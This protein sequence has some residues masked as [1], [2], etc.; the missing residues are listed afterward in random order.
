MQLR[1]LLAWTLVK[2][3][4]EEEAA[5]HFKAMA[6]LDLDAETQ[7]SVLLGL[8]C[9]A[10][11]QYRHRQP[12]KRVREAS[13]S[14]QPARTLEVVEEDDAEHGD[15]DLDIPVIEVTPPP[16]R[17][18]PPSAPEIPEIPVIEELPDG[19]DRAG[20][21]PA[22]EEPKKKK[23]KSTTEFASIEEALDASFE[24]TD[25]TGTSEVPVQDALEASFEFSVGLDD[26]EE[27]P[28]PAGGPQLPLPASQRGAA[29][30][31][32]IAPVPTG[33]ETPEEEFGAEVRL[34]AE[35]AEPGPVEAPER[36]AAADEPEPAAPAEEPRQ[37]RAVEPKAVFTGDL[38][39][40]AVPDLLDFLETSRRTGTLVITSQAGIGAVHLHQGRIT[41][42][43]SPATPNMGDLL[44]ETGAVT[45]EQL[46]SAVQNQQDNC[47]DRLLGAILVEMGIVERAKL[48]EALVKQVKG[49]LMEMVEWLTGRFAFEPDKRSQEETAAE[50]E[51]ELDTRS[52]LLDVLRQVDEQNR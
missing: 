21:P 13:S 20:P 40:F 52:V 51:L 33:E 44:L 18:A 41:G 1:E 35:P 31:E 22:T 3:G 7:S 14:F 47:P 4:R 26:E 6:Y 42:A 43:A 39:L 10:N 8:G 37:A 17:P 32:P 9:L 34:E 16:E 11:R 49:A 50:I 12:A 24:F 5:Q 29:P 48:E 45:G 38:Q 15:E 27:Q 2:V 36:A 19:E 30:V 28:E 23:K 25:P 46:T